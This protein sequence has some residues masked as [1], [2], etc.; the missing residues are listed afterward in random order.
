MDLV[1]WLNQSSES[2]D[3]DLYLDLVFFFFFFFFFFFLLV[4]VLLY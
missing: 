2:G 4:F 3:C 1:W